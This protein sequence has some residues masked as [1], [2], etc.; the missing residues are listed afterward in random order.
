MQCIDCYGLPVVC[1]WFASGLPVVS[2]GFLR[3]PRPGNQGR[4]QEVHQVASRHVL[5]YPWFCF[6]APPQR[7]HF[8]DKSD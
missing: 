6:S 2:S 1:Q 5:K 7:T 3:S 8:K 4:A